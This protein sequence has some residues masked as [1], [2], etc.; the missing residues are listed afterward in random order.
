MQDNLVCNGKVT[1]QSDAEHALEQL[2]DHVYHQ[3]NK[4]EMSINLYNYSNKGLI[5]VS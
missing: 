1:D 4:T 5:N 3:T 2:I